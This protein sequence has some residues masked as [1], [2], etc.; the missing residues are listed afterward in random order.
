M[1][2]FSRRKLCLIG[3]ILLAF[4]AIVAAATA[5]GAALELWD[6]G[7]TVALLSLAVAVGTTGHALVATRCLPPKEGARKPR[8]KG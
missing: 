6:R 2:H 1:P 3:L 8:R 4:S 7:H 5:T